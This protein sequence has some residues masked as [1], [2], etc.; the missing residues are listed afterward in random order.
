MS[1]SG[2]IGRAIREA[3][4]LK[5]R[6]G[7]DGRDN[8]MK[9]KLFCKAIRSGVSLKSLT[10]D[11]YPGIR[12]WYRL[13]KSRGD[14]PL[15]VVEIINRRSTG[16]SVMRTG[17][18]TN[19][20][21]VRPLREKTVITA[22]SSPGFIPDGSGPVNA[23]HGRDPLTGRAYKMNGHPRKL[24]TRTGQF[25]RP[26]VLAQL[27]AM[28]DEGRNLAEIG[29]EFGVSRER[30][31]QVCNGHG[32]VTQSKASLL[33]LRADIKANKASIE[34]L[35]KSG[36]KAADL[37]R[38]YG[39]KT[40]AFMREIRGSISIRKAALAGRKQRSIA[41]FNA[42][43]GRS[44]GKW[45]VV[46]A[47]VCRGNKYLVPVLCE[48]SCGARAYVIYG[49]LYRGYSL[50]CSSCGVASRRRQVWVRDDGKRFASTS[51]MLIDAG[52]RS[53]QVQMHEFR[54]NGFKTYV[55]PNRRVYTPV[56]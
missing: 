3:M 43:K 37:A 13:A 10:R 49:N 4:L 41:Y 42:M 52:E 35:I 7:R 38:I 1:G 34:G 33:R 47:N 24:R 36:S 14:L 44:F 27:K 22:L 6:A 55:A 20:Q 12:D 53:Y 2:D 17:T 40:D 32:W 9:M 19:G 48:C 25:N 16:G 56:K 50:G 46:G 11:A 45:K 29:A 28:I 30:V 26:A 54:R 39:V 31:R 18:K 51:A 5:R 15:D 23:K 21:E 8:P